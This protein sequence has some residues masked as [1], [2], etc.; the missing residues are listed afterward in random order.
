MRLRSWRGSTPLSPT[1][2]RSFPWARVVLLVAALALAAYLVVPNFYY[3]RADALVKGDLVPV[4]A[5]YRVRV[6]RLL[7]NC[8]D[9]VSA[10]QR[11]A[12][13]SNF[14]VQ[15]D[16]QRQ[17]LQ[18]LEQLQLSR[19]AL[20]EQV[21]AARTNMADLHE[22]YLAAALDAKRLGDQF[23]AYDEA[24]RSGAVPRVDW[25]QRQTEW[26]SAV[27]SAE[28]ARYGWQRAEQEV[29]RIGI[30]ENA[31]IASSEQISEQ[32]QALARRVGGEPLLAPVSGYVVNCLERPQNVIQPSTALFDIFQPDRAYVLAY[33]SPSTTDR[34]QIGEPVDVKIAGIP[35]T[36]S[37]RVGSIYPDLAALPAQLTRFFWQRVQWTQYRPVR[38]LL[39]HV[40]PQD[41]ARLYYDAQARISI[42]LHPKQSPQ[43]V[44]RP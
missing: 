13:V 32:A 44:S 37:G 12:L 27:A 38:I 8:N 17:Y 6:D 34:I 4:T 19:I 11:V 25:Q 7:V 39:D 31:R 15:A 36:L 30:D 22:R 18:S 1:P 23:H 21:A 35:H 33:F 14:L 29:K 24:Y 16:Y 10:G 5:L 28:S 3:L 26:Q 9:H 40:K 2:Q 43:S 42:A 20:D 41:R